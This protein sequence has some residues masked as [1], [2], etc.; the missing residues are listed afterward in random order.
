MLP[1]IPDIIN[2]KKKVNFF[3]SNSPILMAKITSI[4]IIIR[5]IFKPSSQPFF[6]AFLPINRPPNN[7]VK[8][9]IIILHMANV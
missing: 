7:N 1:K 2:I 4:P 5:L 6:V 9:G 3:G 8:M